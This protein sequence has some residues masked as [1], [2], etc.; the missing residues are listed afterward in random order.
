MPTAY[1]YSEK[2]SMP[3][4]LDDF[5]ERLSYYIG[6]GMGL[7][8]SFLGIFIT[9]LFAFLGL[10]AL[11]FRRLLALFRKPI[12]RKGGPVLFTLLIGVIVLVV[13]VAILWVKSPE[14]YKS[15]LNKRVIVLG[16]D[17]LD[18][19]ILE[20]MMEN[21]E[22][23][24]FSRLKETGSFSPLATTNPAQTPVVMSSFITGTNPGGHGVF[25][26]LSR[27]PKTYLLELSLARIELPERFLTIGETKFP[28]GRSRIVSHRK[29]TPFWEFTSKERIPTIILF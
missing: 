22:L 23:P 5:R 19:K 13:I 11:S 20:R 26:F 14:S 16:M 8:F 6:P 10:L 15:S 2:S 3:G 29:G 21:K 17:G 1:T 28:L 27:N 9:L 24:N 18:P 12:F 4:S 7:V 25:D